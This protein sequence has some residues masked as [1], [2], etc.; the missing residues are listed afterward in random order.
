MSFVL[1]N[2]DNRAVL[3]AGDF[4]FDVEAMSNGMLSSDPMQ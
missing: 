4:Y 3:V 2:I 1:G